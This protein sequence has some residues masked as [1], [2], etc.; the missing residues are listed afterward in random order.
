MQILIVLFIVVLQL[1]CTKFQRANVKVL[2]DALD[3][4]EHSHPSNDSGNVASLRWSDNEYIRK[5]IDQT[6]FK[7]SM[8]DQND[9]LAL[10]SFYDRPELK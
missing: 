10:A 8:D 4:T 1:S 6:N 2:R 9:I 3:I 5:T 7:F